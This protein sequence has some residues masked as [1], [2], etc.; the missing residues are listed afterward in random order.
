M[1]VR[2]KDVMCRSFRFLIREE[3]RHE[4]FEKAIE[5]ENMIKNLAKKLGCIPDTITIMKTGQTKFIKWQIV[6]KLIKITG[7][8]EE[9]L[10]L[11]ILAI[12]GGMSGKI[13]EVKF[14]IKESP[15][16]ALL[17][18]KGMGD[19]SIEKNFRFSFWNKKEELIEEVCS[20]VNKAIG[21]TRGTVN[22]FKD[23]RIQVK[24][25][26]FIG[27][28]LHM[29]GVPVGNKTLQN[30]DVPIWIKNGSKEMKASFIRGLFDD[31]SSIRMK[32]E[33]N[34]NRSIILAQGKLTEL[35]SSLENFFSSVKKI[36]LIDFG[37]NSSKITEQETFIDKKGRKKVVLKFEI[38]SKDNFE[39][40]LNNIGF[41]HIEKKRK[42]EECINS[43]VDIHRSKNIILEMIRNS[44]KPLSTTEI[45][46]L[47]GINRNLA[48]SHL[49]K[50]LK[51]GE[52]FKS[53]FQRKRKYS[54]QL[55]ILV[56]LR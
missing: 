47:T 38:R 14:P 45:S 15:E 42:L 25:C 28:V 55:K 50:L 29:F 10:E 3:F 6:E 46:K 13:T 35:R 22:K 11:N 54:K 26:P 24:F 49:D 32:T 48:L 27:F 56:H 37:I 52:I 17:I 41:T 20:C 9:E 1:E 40:F 21:K 16:L 23:G 7:I 5:K 51:N 18:G 34:R 33:K 2:L 12:K 30:F 36:L 43:F 31:E 53:K 8:S 19:G 44:P 4:L 39:R